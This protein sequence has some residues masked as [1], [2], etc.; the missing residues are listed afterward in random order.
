MILFCETI[1]NNHIMYKIEKPSG[2]I[3]RKQLPQLKKKIVEQIDRFLS[4][5]DTVNWVEA[6]K[7]KNF[8]LH[9]KV[10]GGSIT[11]WFLKWL[12]E[13]AK[14]RIE[15]LLIGDMDFLLS[16]VDM[17][18]RKRQSL[19][20][21]KRIIYEKISQTNYQ[22][23]FNNGDAISSEDLIEKDVFN[24]I[25]YDIFVAHGYNEV[26]DKTEHVKGL[27]LRICPYCGRSFIYSVEEETDI[28]KPQ[29]DHF[30]PKRKYPYLALSYFNLL[31]VCPTCN[32]SSCKGEY[33]PMINIG[34][35]PFRIVYP[36][37]YD[38]K[39]VEFKIT[40]NGSNYYQDSN[41]DVSIDYHGDTKLANASKNVMKLDEFYKLHNREVG[42]IYRQF[43]LLKSKV[44]LYYKKYEL[45]RFAFSPSPLLF[46]GYDFN[47]ENSQKEILY[48]LKKEAYEQIEKLV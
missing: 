29:I 6:V 2:Y 19:G 21:D 41:Y 44:R 9:A 35:R 1:C 12:K 15:K 26:F 48:K 25:V 8:I 45:S 27:N 7:N 36:Y 16:V 20:V 3:L 42:D 18:E 43:M 32:L 23:V 47:E 5:D 46:F 14:D 31:P 39:K 13:S 34:S 40:L 24:A 17:V 11:E 33:D 38:D 22:K 28:V 10:E 30:L 4:N 37:E